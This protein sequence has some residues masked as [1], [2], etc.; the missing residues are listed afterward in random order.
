MPTVP[1]PSDEQHHLAQKARIGETL[2][3]YGLG[4][5][6]KDRDLLLSVF[7]PDATASYDGQTWLE[8]GAHIVDWLLGALG[9]LAYSQHLITVPRITVDGDAASAT[10]YLSSHQCTDADPVTLIR[11]NGRYQC[12]LRQ[13][14]GEWRISRLTLSIGWSETRAS[15]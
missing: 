11:M 7:A 15:T 3:S 12:E 4:C 8:G 2:Q 6:E 1:V 10:A 9:G 14:D 5:D 13:I